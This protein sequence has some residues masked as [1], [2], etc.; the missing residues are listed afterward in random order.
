MFALQLSRHAVF[1]RG[2]EAVLCHFLSQNLHH[3]VVSFLIQNCTRSEIES[4]LYDKYVATFSDLKM[5]LADSGLIC[6]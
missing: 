2:D 5:L 1:V 3:S 4:L 6:S